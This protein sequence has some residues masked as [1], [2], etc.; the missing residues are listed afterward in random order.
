MIYV[1]LTVMYDRHVTDDDWQ[2][3]HVLLTVD[4]VI[5]TLRDKALQPAASRAWRRTVRGSDGAARRFPATTRNPSIQRLAANSTKKLEW[6]QLR[7]NLMSS[8]C[9][10]TPAVIPQ[11]GWC[12]SPTWRYF[13]D[14]RTLS[15]ARD[16]AAARLVRADEVLD[17]HLCL[18]FDHCRIAADGAEQARRKLENSALATAFCGPTFT[19]SELQQVYEAVWGISLDPRNF[20]R[21]VL[22]T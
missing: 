5:L 22:G 20:Y 13:R 9:T 11:G 10:E 7:S 18:A 14:C 6:K 2:P 19:I 21:K 16:A 4:L 15:P 3:P 1:S 12:P 17:G 8:A